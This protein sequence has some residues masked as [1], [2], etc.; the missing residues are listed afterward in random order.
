M[1]IILKNYL[2]NSPP[3][4]I[5]L[6]VISYGKLSFAGQGAGK[7]PQK[8]PVSYQIAYVV[9]PNK[10]LTMLP[11][12]LPFIDDVNR[13]GMVL[14]ALLICNSDTLTNHIFFFL[15]LFFITSTHFTY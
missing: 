14:K 2:Q 11:I 13:S 3:G 9:P 15:F 4:S 12:M 6:G 5:L 8:N 1:L 7:N 10:V